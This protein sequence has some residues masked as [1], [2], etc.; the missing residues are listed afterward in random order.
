METIQNFLNNF[1]MPVKKTTLMNNAGV[2]TP[3]GL[4]VGHESD[5]DSNQASINKVNN[6]YK[7]F[8]MPNIR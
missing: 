8:S 6:P 1:V 4:Q 7:K 5:S 3:C 2:A